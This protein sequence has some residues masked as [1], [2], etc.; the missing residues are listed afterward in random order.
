MPLST[1]CLPDAISLCSASAFLRMLLALAVFLKSAPVA[2]GRGGLGGARVGLGGDGVVSF[3][4]WTE[5]A[6]SSRFSTGL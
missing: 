6:D 1:L 2:V 4:C 5:S 3:S